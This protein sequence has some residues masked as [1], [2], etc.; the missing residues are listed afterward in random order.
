MPS[1]ASVPTRGNMAMTKQ[2]YQ[3]P[4]CLTQIIPYIC[5]SFIISYLFEID[6]PFFRGCYLYN[7]YFINPP[8]P[9]YN[10]TVLTQIQNIHI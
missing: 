1:S 4:G 9:N 2:G 6:P 5:L 3:R 7:F 10:C 8:L